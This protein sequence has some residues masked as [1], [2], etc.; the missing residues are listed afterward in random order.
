MW[1]VSLTHPMLTLFLCGQFLLH[2]PCWLLFLIWGVSLTHLMLTLYLC[3]SFS[4][5]SHVGFFFLNLGSFSY[6][7]RADFV[8]MWGVSLTHPMLTFFWCK[9]FLSHIRY[10]LLFLTWGVSLTHPVLTFFLCGEFLIHIPC[11]LL[12]FECGEFLLHIPCWLCFYVGSF[13]YTSRAG[14]ISIWGVSL[15]H[16]VLSS[17]FAGE[18]LWQIPSLLFFLCGEFFLHIPGC[19]DVYARSFSYTSRA[20]TKCTKT[21]LSV[22]KKGGREDRQAKEQARAEK[23]HKWTDPSS[24]NC[25]EDNPSKK[26]LDGRR[27]R[28]PA[29]KSHTQRRERS[30]T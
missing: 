3:E 9:E 23:A 14:F 4:Y 22:S 27:L 25:S 1:G 28:K 29:W 2:I 7:S 10:W 17:F 20:E 19:I 15:T 8:F 26:E 5:T 24:A 12:F 30:P 21:A 13:S 18:F 16:P 11:W 6:T